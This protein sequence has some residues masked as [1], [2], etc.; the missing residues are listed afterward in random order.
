MVV[1]VM[2]MMNGGSGG[3]GMMIGVMEVRG[4]C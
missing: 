4:C 2:I 1:V 3:W